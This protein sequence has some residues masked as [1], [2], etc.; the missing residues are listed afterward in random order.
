MTLLEVKAE[1]D[2][3]L[4]QS[5]LTVRIMIQNMDLLMANRELRLSYSC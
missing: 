1:I 4:K 2:T 3:F 5:L